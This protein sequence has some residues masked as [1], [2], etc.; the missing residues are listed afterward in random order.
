MIKATPREYRFAHQ[1]LVHS[2][3]QTE[4]VTLKTNQGE[5]VVEAVDDNSIEATWLAYN[6]TRKTAPDVRHGSEVMLYKLG[7]NKYYWTETNTQDMKRLESIIF[8]ISAD[9]NNAMDP[10]YSNAYF[11]SWSSHDKRLLVRINKVDGEFTGYTSE[12]NAIDGYAQTVDDLGNVMFVNSRDTVVGL[13]NA[14]GTLVYLNKKDIIGYAPENIKLT[15]QQLMALKARS[16]ALS[17][18]DYECTAT[19]SYKVNTPNAVFSNE[20][21]TPEATINGIK[22]SKHKHLEQGDGKPVS[23]PM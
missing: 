16:I 2:N 21:T 12:I 20:I 4:S 3:P 11:V 7:D 17:C 18:E 5:Q 15:A 23:E 9:P 14:D 19:S 8:A 22:H 1:E 13:E 10:N 6:T